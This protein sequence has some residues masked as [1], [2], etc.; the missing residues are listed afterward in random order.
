MEIPLYISELMTPTVIFY[1]K[2]QE[3]ELLKFC[4]SRDITFLPSDDFNHIYTLEDGNGRIGRLIMNK[5]LMDNNYL[6]FIIYTSNKRKHAKAF[7]KLMENKNIQFNDFL[8]KQYRKSLRLYYKLA[9]ELQKQNK[10][11][12]SKYF[13]DE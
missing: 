3:K 5:I 6:P 7:D 4:L 12:K 1:E 11:Y 9:V 10:I 8:V 13:K 2:E